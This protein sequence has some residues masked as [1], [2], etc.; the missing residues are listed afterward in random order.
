MTAFGYDQRAT[1]PRTVRIA[2]AGV[3]VLGVLNI[4]RVVVQT[5]LTFTGDG[6]SGGARAMFLILNVIP[7]AVSVLLLPLAHQMIRGRPWAWIT[8][9]VVAALASLIGAFLLL[10]S[11]FGEGFPFIALTTFVVP[12]GVLLALTV[13]PSVRAFFAAK[14]VPRPYPPYPGPGS[15]TS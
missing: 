3:A 14:P 6:W 7:F 11:L 4:L 2:A 13:P 9:V 12:L 10:G 8:A 1:T 15:W 5:A